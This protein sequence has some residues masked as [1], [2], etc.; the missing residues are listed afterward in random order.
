VS[1]PVVVDLGLG[2]GT[3]RERFGYDTGEVKRMRVATVPQ[4]VA[5]GDP[6]GDGK[7]DLIVA[8]PSGVHV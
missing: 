5:A 7:L 6:N 1:R 4:A 8:G 2:N 3:F